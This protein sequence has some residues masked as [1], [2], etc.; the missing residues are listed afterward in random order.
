VNTFVIYSHIEE[1]RLNFIRCS[2]HPPPDITDGNHVENIELPASF[3]GSC[4]WASEQTTADSLA[5][6]CT[7]GHPSFFYHH[8]LQS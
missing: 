5:L 6:A 3:L 2:Q 4:K 7:Y 8:D 1:E